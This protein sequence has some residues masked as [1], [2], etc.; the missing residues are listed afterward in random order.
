MDVNGPLF[1]WR[2]P[3][4]VRGV[5]R[6]TPDD[7]SQWAPLDVTMTAPPAN[8]AWAVS[9]LLPGGSGNERSMRRIM[10]WNLITL[11]GFFE[12]PAPWDLDWHNEVWGDELEQLGLEQLRGADLLVFGRAT[13]QGMAA[14]WPSASGAIADLMNRTG[15]VVFS[16]TLE[17]ADWANTR[18]IREL[19]PAVVRE[20]KEGGDGDILVFGSAGLSAA[21]ME[22]DLFDEYRLL[23]A[24]VV[25][26]EGTTLFGRG[27]AR[28]R[29]R[30]LEARPFASGGVLL[31]YAPAPPAST[32]A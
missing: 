24:P 9:G 23:M 6:F 26:G 3:R 29:L 20:L 10:M 13:Y 28:R 21:L 15:K 7:S 14:Y 25:L 11:D 17:T 32:E 19:D 30:L 2:R 12:G 8:D 16:R 4:L 5:E 1:C 22:A 27:L 18:V 31:R